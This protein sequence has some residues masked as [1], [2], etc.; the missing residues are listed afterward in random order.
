MDKKGQMCE[1]RRRE[2]D[3]QLCT[4]NCQGIKCNECISE[5][6]LW[7]VGFK[8]TNIKSSQK[9]EHQ[10][11]PRRGT[12]LTADVNTGGIHSHVSEGAR[13]HL[14]E[15]CSAVPSAAASHGARVAAPGSR[16]RPLPPL[17]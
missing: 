9:G 3:L 13:A 16:L 14:H 7:L 15:R 8:L 6:K 10:A 4:S 5:T 12:R 1:K 2:Y 17:V 11:S